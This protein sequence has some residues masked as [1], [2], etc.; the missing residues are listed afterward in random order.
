MTHFRLNI[1][2]EVLRSNFSGNAYLPFFAAR[3][4]VMSAVNK[5]FNCFA[6]D[7]TSHQN[8]RL[9]TNNQSGFLRNHN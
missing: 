8:S 4:I 9:Q 3:P 6:E 7:S 1:S 5:T 2:T